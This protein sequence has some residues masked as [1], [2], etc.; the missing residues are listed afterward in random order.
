VLATIL[1]TALGLFVML[2][3]PND[4]K[5]HELLAWIASISLSTQCVLMYLCVT[6]YC[7][8]KQFLY[9]EYGMR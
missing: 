1:L 7:D 5:G 2:Q 4:N 6:W 8:L 9:S 3:I